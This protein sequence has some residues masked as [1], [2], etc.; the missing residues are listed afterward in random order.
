M[1]IGDVHDGSGLHHLLWELVANVLDEHLAGHATQ[2][3][4]A[5]EADGSASVE[6]DGR[7]IPVELRGDRGGTH[8][9]V[10][11][12]TLCAGSK[13]DSRHRHVHVGLHG[14]GLAAVNAVCSTM[15]V[16]V[17]RDGHLHRQS[18]G[19]G[20][21]VSSLEVVGRTSKRGTR[22]EIRPDDT[23]FTRT[24]FDGNLVRER[25]G[26][27][28]ALLPGLRVRFFDK[29]TELTSPGIG[30]LARRLAGNAKR[31][32]HEPLR[33]SSALGGWRALRALDGVPGVEVA[34]FWTLS[35][36][37]PPALHG[38]VNMQRCDEGTHVRALAGA[39]QPLLADIPP[40]QR[41]DL[42]RC[43]AARV[44]GV[45]SVLHFDPR[46]G[47]PTRSRLESPD[48]APVLGRTVSTAVERF[49]AER[50]DQALALVASARER[51]A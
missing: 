26:E 37:A 29:R 39:M 43:L 41:T 45:I 11:M 4:V 21:P 27:L 22:V 36:E 16:T 10:V 25:L 28:A 23:I 18:F 2:L 50:P 3:V 17:A 44:G 49:V 51:S 14:V 15:T 7:G 32:P 30:D 38:F 5:L 13:L 40:T 8:L 20:V 47:S 19:R 42:A 31:V 12:T 9:E 46:F 1:Y 35:D 6:D 34:L 33:A 48:V 24:D